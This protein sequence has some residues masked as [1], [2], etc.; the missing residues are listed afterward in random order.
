MISTQ[1]G[2]SVGFPGG[3]VAKNLPE[4]QQ[5]QEMQLWSLGWEDLLEKISIHSS[6]PAWEIL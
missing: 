4:M 2:F 5:T 3:S 6:I 1:W